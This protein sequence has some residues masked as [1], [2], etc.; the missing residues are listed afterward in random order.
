MNRCAGEAEE[1]RTCEGGANCCQ[2]ISEHVSVA[3]IDD[4]D[5]S[6]LVDTVELVTVAGL[7]HNTAHLLNRGD[8]EGIACVGTIQFGN[9]IIGVVGLLYFLYLVFESAIFEC[10]LRTEFDSVH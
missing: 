7:W 6:L 3:L 5:E 9:Q 4:Y 8:D 10:S 1:D 2:H